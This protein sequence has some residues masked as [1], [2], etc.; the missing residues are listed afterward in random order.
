MKKALLVVLAF[1]VVSVL[2]TVAWNEWLVDAYA[3]VFRTI[4]PAVYGLL[5]AD[6]TLVY[7][8]R[9]RYINFV[10]F[11]SLVV[12]TPGIALRRRLVGLL[13]GI[14]ALVVAHLVLNWTARFSPGSSLPVVP[15]IVSD[16]L[17]FL[18]WLVV[19]YPVLVGLL[20]GSAGTEPNAGAG[21]EPKAGAGT[22]AKV[23]VRPETREGVRASDAGSPARSDGVD[24]PASSEQREHDPH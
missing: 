4:A 6:D 16:T 22:E 12:V 19:A 13:L 5:G 23:G 14:V 24:D 15:A 3:V 20:P 11:V 9:G 21:T 17:P 8:R 18:F 7:A 10:P 2:L 1:C